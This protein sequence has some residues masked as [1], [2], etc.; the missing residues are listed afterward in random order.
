MPNEDAEK[1]LVFLKHYDLFA[2]LLNKGG[3]EPKNA[4][5]TLHFDNSGILQ[6]VHRSDILYSKRFDH[7]I[8]P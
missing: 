1:Y 7:P 4:S 8:R 5:V 6:A 3:F 2:L